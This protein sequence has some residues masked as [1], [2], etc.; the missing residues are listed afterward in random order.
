VCVAS[1]R[2]NNNSKNQKIKAQKKRG[3]KIYLAFSLFFPPV[4]VS[5][6]LLGL[7]VFF[8]FLEKK[9]Q[10]DALRQQEVGENGLNRIRIRSADDE[11]RRKEKDFFQ[12]VSRGR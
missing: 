9:T 12:K 3:K 4:V 10:R 11:L 2:I 1:D 7:L 6:F 5:F 8:L